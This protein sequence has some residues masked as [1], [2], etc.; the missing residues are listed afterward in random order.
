MGGARGSASSQP[1]FSAG[2]L[3]FHYGP[4]EALHS[5]GPAK[6]NTST[7]A[8]VHEEALQLSPTLTTPAQTSF[9]TEALRSRERQN[10]KTL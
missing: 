10:T 3:R 7:L 2:A 9:Q 6:G 8:T 4:E 5:A 1:P